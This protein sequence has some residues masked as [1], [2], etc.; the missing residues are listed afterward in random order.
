MIS[1]RTGGIVTVDA[2]CR[3]GRAKEVGSPQPCSSAAQL[4][5]TKQSVK[6]M[7]VFDQHVMYPAAAGF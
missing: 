5:E 4:A 3:L 7:L 2:D 1:C 6:N